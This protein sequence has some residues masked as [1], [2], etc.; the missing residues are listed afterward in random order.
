[1]NKKITVF[2]IASLILITLVSAGIVTKYTISNVI[3]DNKKTTNNILEETFEYKCDGVPIQTIASEP[4]GKWDSNDV[5]SVLHN[6]SGIV[7][8][9]K[10]NGILYKENKYGVR[11]FDETKLMEDECVKDENNWDANKNECTTLKIS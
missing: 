11:S 9:I 7:T 1:M 8:D 5:E 3:I 10:K 6:C 2:L 4:D